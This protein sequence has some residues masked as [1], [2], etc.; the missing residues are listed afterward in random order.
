MKQG[1]S[2]AETLH[3]LTSNGYQIA[4]PH[5][6]T[7]ASESIHSDDWRLDS[8]YQVQKEQELP[9]KALVIAVSSSRRHLKLVF[10]E[11][12]IPKHDFSP[13]G[14]L[15]RLFPLKTTRHQ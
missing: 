13:M 6:P 9:S 1:P 15:R 4:D 11:D 3:H 12:M 8:M 5:I 2:L 14:L 10:V 7:H